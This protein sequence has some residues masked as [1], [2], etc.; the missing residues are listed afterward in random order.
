MLM[1]YEAVVL[2]NA[3][4]K[5]VVLPG[6]G[7]DVVQYLFKPLDVDFTASSPWGLHPRRSGR[8]LEEYEGGWQLI[9]PNGG[10]PSRY[11]GAEWE[12]HD[13]V[14]NRQWT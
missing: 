2:E 8:F 5:A 7:M 4:A 12:Q 14:S 6:K 13:E 10:T 1:G 11:R 9:F 3:W